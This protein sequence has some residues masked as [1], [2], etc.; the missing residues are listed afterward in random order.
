MVRKLASV[1][2]CIAAIAAV[3]PCA[4]SAQSDYPNKPLRLI[5]PFP[6]GGSTDIIG[7]IVA[8]R[9]S[10]KLGQQIVVDNRGGAGG[11]IGTDAAAKASPDGTFP[12][13]ATAPPRSRSS[14]TKSRPSSVPCRRCCS[15]SR[16]TSCGRSRSVRLA[17]RPPCPT[18][19]RW[20]S[21][22]I[23]DSRR[24]SGSASSLRRERPRGPSSAWPAN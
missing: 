24:R 10:E 21:W 8:Q 5:V 22:A 18:F 16:R 13:R 1:A 12:T 2:A 4:V 15:K 7:R 20:P 6:P 14:R 9:L 11:T 3:F 17:A 23:R 19:R